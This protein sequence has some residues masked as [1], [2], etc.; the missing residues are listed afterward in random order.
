MEYQACPCTLNH[1]SS[2]RLLHE[3]G[4]NNMKSKLQWR[5]DPL[6]PTTD[7]DGFGCHVNCISTTSGCVKAAV[8]SNRLLALAANTRRDVGFKSTK[9]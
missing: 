8:V 2:W 7:T 6:A 5:I 1:W 9:L 3:F 4:L